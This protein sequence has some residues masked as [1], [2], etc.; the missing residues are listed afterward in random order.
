MSTPVAAM[1]VGELASEA[2]AW[3]DNRTA[4]TAPVAVSTI[5]IAP[6]VDSTMA[7]LRPPL[8]TASATAAD[9]SSVV[10]VCRGRPSSRDSVNR[11][12]V[13][14]ATQVQEIPPSVHGQIAA[15]FAGQSQHSAMTSAWSGA[16]EV[17]ARRGG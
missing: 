1:Y 3:A 17:S 16:G 2:A 5:V 7:T 9:D 6:L 4:S 13:C 10:R 12:R 11:W 15:S 8:T 14:P